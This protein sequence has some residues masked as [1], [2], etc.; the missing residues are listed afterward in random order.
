M[1]KKR[2]MDSLLQEYLEDF[3]AVLI[4]G[5]KDVGKTSTCQEFSKTEYHLDMRE[6]LSIVQADASI[7]FRQELPVLIDEWQRF[8]EIWDIVRREVDA[9]LPLGSVLLTGSSPSLHQGLHS[10]SGR[11]ERLKMRPFSIE[12]RELAEPVITIK[13]LLTGVALTVSGKTALTLSDYI[14][15]IYKSGFPGIR[16]RS[17]RA[18]KRSLASYIDNIIERDFQENNIIVRKPKALMAWLKTYAAA[19]ATTTSFKT[20]LEAALANENISPSTKTATSYRDLLQNIGIIEELQPWIKMGKIFSNIAKAP[21]HF[22]LDPAL[23]VTLLNITRETLLAGQPPKVIGTLNKSFLGQIFESFVYQSLAVYAEVNEAELSHFRTS[24]GT[25]EI[26]F[27]IEKDD[28]IV[29]IEV[30][31]KSAITTHDVRHLNWFEEKV[32]DE[33]KVQKIIVTTGSQAYT[34]QDGVHVVPV[35]LLG[36]I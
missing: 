15:E 4:E 2:L 33:F 3:P 14:D 8:P 26:D 21:K 24:D 5:A 23:S 13:T 35:A 20:I 36:A 28:V 25:R 10:G 9:D 17:E 31:S 29:L 18:I 34:R 1:Y 7:L 22:L 27:I 6:Q 32:K 30:K 11:I 19:T 16:V 12:E